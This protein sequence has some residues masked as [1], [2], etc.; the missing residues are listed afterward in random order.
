[1]GEDDI[2]TAFAGKQVLSY[3]FHLPRRAVFQL[4]DT[5]A[6]PLV[7]P[8]FRRLCRSPVPEIE[9]ITWDRGT[10]LARHKSLTAATGVAVYFAD[11][12]SPWQRGTTENTNKLIRQYLP[13]GVDLSAYTQGEL[14]VI[15][16]KLNNRP[17]KILG[18]MTPN[19]ASGRS[20]ALT[21]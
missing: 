1:M 7:R 3:S 19:E 6:N 20:V 17:R 2:E 10:E 16:E 8:H 5:L 11:A 21:G 4:P 13:K 15:A 18:Y 14:D 9:S 12:K